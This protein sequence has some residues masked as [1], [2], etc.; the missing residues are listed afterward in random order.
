MCERLVGDK[1]RTRRVRSV[2]EN[3]HCGGKS[4]AENPVGEK[5]M[6]GSLLVR[7]VGG[8]AVG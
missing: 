8:K 5:P 1:A 4:L 2:A 6:M 3:P 7:I